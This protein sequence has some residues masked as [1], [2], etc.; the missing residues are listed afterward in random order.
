[1]R[2]AKDPG[3]GGLEEAGGAGFRAVVAVDVLPGAGL[4]A[5]WG[6]L[7]RGFAADAVAAFAGA[8]LLEVG[9]SDFEG[10]RSCS[11]AFRFVPAT[12]LFFSEES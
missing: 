2:S 8:G 4:A 10:R 5:F 6:G 9:L 3:G 12:T 7:G 1:M 11:S